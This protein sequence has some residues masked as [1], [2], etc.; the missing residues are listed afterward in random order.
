[1]EKRKMQ[2]NHNNRISNHS[3]IVNEHNWYSWKTL[4]C[5][6]FSLRISA[7]NTNSLLNKSNKWNCIC[8]S[9]HSL[10]QESRAKQIDVKKI[11][12]RGD[13]M[14]IFTLIFVPFFSTLDYFQIPNCRYIFNTAPPMNIGERWTSCWCTI[15]LNTC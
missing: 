14:I 7:S 1:M 12:R 8:C 2:K 3:S 6:A 15:H 11:I 9:L 10:N 4:K 13:E 5:F